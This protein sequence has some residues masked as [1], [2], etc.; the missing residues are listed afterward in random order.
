[1]LFPAATKLFFLI[2]PDGIFCLS[3]IAISPIPFTAVKEWLYR[4]AVTQ[5]SLLTQ[6]KLISI[7]QTDLIREVEEVFSI[8]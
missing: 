7:S 5:R 8:G 4:N 2:S 6:K 3:F 1:M